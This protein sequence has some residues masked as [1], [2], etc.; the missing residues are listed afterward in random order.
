MREFQQNTEY[1]QT[2]REVKLNHMLRDENEN[3]RPRL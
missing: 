1:K 2:I 3:S